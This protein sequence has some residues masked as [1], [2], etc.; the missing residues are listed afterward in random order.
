MFYPYNLQ[1]LY[2]Y[3]HANNRTTAGNTGPIILIYI[4]SFNVPK[5]VYIQHDFGHRLVFL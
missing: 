5:S 2:I 3:I 1:I 4:A